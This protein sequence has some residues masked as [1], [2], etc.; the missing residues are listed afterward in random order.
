[1]THKEILESVQK[2]VGQLSDREECPPD[3]DLMDEADLSSIEI[4]ELLCRL[5]DM[6]GIKIAPR[7]LRLVATVEDLA[8]L[9]W[10]KLKP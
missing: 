6:Y 3:L 2:M 4:M 7:D 9:V 5:E 10:E 8:G 1:M